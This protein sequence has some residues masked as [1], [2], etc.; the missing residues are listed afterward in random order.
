MIDS[1]VAN[2]SGVERVIVI[3]ER[4]HGV[5]SVAPILGGAIV[6]PECL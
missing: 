2:G 1:G 3:V 6:F 5:E 4:A